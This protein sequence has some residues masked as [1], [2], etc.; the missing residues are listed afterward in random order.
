[1]QQRGEALCLAAAIY[2]GILRVVMGVRRGISPRYRSPKLVF[3]S[4]R[5]E[6]E[7]NRLSRNCCE[8]EIKIRRKER[9]KER[10]E[11]IGNNN[12]TSVEVIDRATC[13]K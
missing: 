6:L 10:N 12:N 5:A 1:M 11:I 9:R 3:K 8:I 4:D 7:T 2:S 13:R